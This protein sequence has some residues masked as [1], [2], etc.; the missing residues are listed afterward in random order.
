MSLASIQTMKVEAAMALARK[1]FAAFCETTL[2]TEDGQPMRPDRHHRVWTDKLQGAVERKEAGVPGQSRVFFVSPP[3]HAKTSYASIAFPLWYMGRLPGDAIALVSN[4]D[5]LAKKFLGGISATVRW[6][7]IYK[8]VFPHIEPDL[9]RRW[10]VNEIYIKRGHRERPDPTIS[11][12]GLGGAIIGRRLDLIIVDDPINEKLAQSDT[13]MERMK[14]WFK[15]TL[16]SRLK[17]NGIILVIM[18]RWSLND[19]GEDLLDPAMRFQLMHMKALADDDSKRVV[20]YQHDADT[21]GLAEGGLIH[22]NGPALWPER[23]PAAS[24][25]PDIETLETRRDQ[26]GNFIWSAMYQGEPMSGEYTVFQESDFRYYCAV[27]GLRGGHQTMCTCPPAS[28][29][30]IADYADRENWRRFQAVDPAMTERTRSDY[31]AIVTAGVDTNQNIFLMNCNRRQTASPAA[32]IT[33]EHEHWF[34]IQA[35]GIEKAGW[36]TD[37]IREIRSTTLLPLRS[38]APDAD[39]RTRALSHATNYENHKVYHPKRARWLG[40]F[41][42]E[43]I[44]FTGAKNA[45]GHDDMVDANVYL[46]RLVSQHRQ[47]M[48][49]K[50]ARYLK[51]Q[52]RPTIAY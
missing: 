30:E 3:D 2:E 34:P 37:L 11:A 46:G 22:E 38:M 26:V 1:Q 23:Y 51:T 4:T 19:L 41:E 10:N 44:A 43:H 45:P 40:D 39:K 20:W 33:Y 42:R 7:E 48:Q 28:D 5:E 16:L 6:N 35:I 36:Q 14:L 32:L 13:E 24:T 29:E 21:G 8:Q 9:E 27:C 31:T 15:R 17:P 49:G 12:I 50:P 52:V 25:N 47:K 18:T